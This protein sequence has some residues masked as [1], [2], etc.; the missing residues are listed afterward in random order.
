MKKSS[1]K[2]TQTGEM[3]HVVKR[4]HEDLGLDLQHP[5]KNSGNVTYA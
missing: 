3:A 2:P 1:V 4:L 5:C